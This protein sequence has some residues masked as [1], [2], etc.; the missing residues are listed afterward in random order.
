MV[1]PLARPDRKTVYKHMDLEIPKTIEIPTCE[2]CGAEWIDAP[3]AAVLDSA[4]EEIYQERMR[5]AARYRAEQG[6]SGKP[7]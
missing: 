1:V 3:T 7:G 4:L 2:K 6:S 5:S